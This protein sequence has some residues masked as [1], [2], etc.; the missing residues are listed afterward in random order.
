MDHFYYLHTNGDL[1]YKRFEPESDSPFV[2][3]VWRID[4]SDRA[5]AWRV[6]F[7]AMALG[8]NLDRIGELAS[9]WK[10]DRADFKEMLTR[11]ATRPTD[12]MKKG[13]P[14]FAVD[15]LGFKDVREFDRWIFN[16]CPLTE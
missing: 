13:L 9:K 1:I 5:D 10:L 11:I 16:G 2:K 14:K 3:K 12:L 6:V 4:L 7:E 15:F 8:A